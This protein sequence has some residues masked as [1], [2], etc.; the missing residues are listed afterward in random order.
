[1]LEKRH[2]KA[3]RGATTASFATFVALVSHVAAGA[4]VP[5]L[6]GIIV[7]LALALPVCVAISGRKLSLLALSA[8]VAVS[9]ALFHALFIFGTTGFAVPAGHAHHTAEPIALPV[10][11]EG[12]AHLLLAAGPA[13]LAAHAAA[14]VVTVAMLYR[15]ELAVRGLLLAGRRMLGLH[16]AVLVLLPAPEKPAA[17]SI[18]AVTLVPRASNARELLPVHAYRGPPNA[19]I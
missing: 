15:G 12:S 18:P 7:P 6:L 10:A 14:A 9:Q 17:A 8:S 19:F 16:R 1:M 3:L 2:A 5:G 13:M 11:G 4:H